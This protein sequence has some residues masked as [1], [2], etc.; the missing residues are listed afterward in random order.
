M[1]FSAG[2]K[3]FQVD[4]V[5]K[6]AIVEVLGRHSLLPANLSQ[7]VVHGYSPLSMLS[8][9]RH[10]QAIYPHSVLNGLNGHQVVDQVNRE[11][12]SQTSTYTQLVTSKLIAA[13]NA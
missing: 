10:P 5:N 7:P 2:L 8:H 3:D 11:N 1:A 12:D 13:C 4:E 9:C 6:K